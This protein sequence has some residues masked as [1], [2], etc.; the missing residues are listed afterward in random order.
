MQRIT[1]TIDDDLLETVDAFAARRGYATR[2]EAMRE[3]LRRAAALQ[4]DGDQ[5]RPCVAALSYV[6][7][8]H[9]RELSQRITK[10]FHDHHD[11]TVASMHV[12]L[13]QG[14]CLEVA[15]LAGATEAVH[16]FA[17][18]VT[19]QRGVRHGELHVIP[20]V[21]YGRPGQAPPHA[22]PHPHPHAHSHP[23][24]HAPSHDP[25]QAHA[26]ALSDAV[27]GA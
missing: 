9:T 24:P 1:I 3:L 20:G 5:D 15:V 25:E 16:A 10:A 11:L 7:D 21:A 26:A 27:D 6:Y 14:S 23:H 2:S 12:H 18:A 8:H 22:H 17:D 19:A 13:D 4:P